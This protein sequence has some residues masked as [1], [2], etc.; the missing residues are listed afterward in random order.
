MLGAGAGDPP[1][2]PLTVSV[3]H[4]A[5]SAPAASAPAAVAAPAPAAAPVVPTKVSELRGTTVPFNGM[6]LAVSKNMIESLKVRASSPRLHVMPPQHQQDEALGELFESGREPR[7]RRLG[8]RFVRAE[9]W[10]EGI[11][12]GIGY[13]LCSNA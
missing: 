4:P 9:Q 11:A 7:L 3:L 10:L 5:A 8:A 13:R 1:A 6:Q 12:Y 2:D